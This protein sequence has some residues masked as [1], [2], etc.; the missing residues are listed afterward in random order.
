MGVHTRTYT[1]PSCAY[2]S[3]ELEWSSSSSSNHASTAEHYGLEV[4][5]AQQQSWSTSGSGTGCLVPSHT[6]VRAMQFAVAA[7]LTNGAREG[8]SRLLVVSSM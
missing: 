6:A 2:S 1:Q 4:S 8:P 7:A 3:T 5:S